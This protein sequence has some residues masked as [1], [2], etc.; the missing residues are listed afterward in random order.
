[1]KIKKEY[2]L[3]GFLIILIFIIVRFFL[4]QNNIP[5]YNIVPEEKISD[6]NNNNI[7]IEEK[8]TG[9]HLVTYNQSA[10]QNSF[11]DNIKIT[12]SNDDKVRFVIGTIDENSFV[13][14][15]FSFE[16]ECKKGEN[17][18]NLFKQRYFVKKGEYLFMD[19]F[20]Q[21]ILFTNEDKNVKSLVQ[22]DADKVAGNM[23]IK[24]SNYILPF[25]YSLKEVKD[26][27]VLFIGN[28]ITT[29]NGGKGIDATSDEFDYYSITKTR[30]ENMFENLNINRVNIS[31]WE[32]LTGTTER[33]LWLQENIKDELFQN[34]DLIIIQLGE[35][36]KE[37]DIKNMETD[38]AN[39]IDKIRKNSQNTEIIWLGPW[40]N[41][42]ENMLLSIPGICEKLNIKY[43]RLNDLYNEEYKSLNLEISK[44]EFFPNNEGMQVI[45]NRIIETLGFEF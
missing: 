7:V 36:Y 18:F 30:L 24:E 11:I 26:F 19:D 43:I 28:D 13:N 9:Y 16:L 23:I 27:S 25:E 34:R 1:M 39:L 8:V 2:F 10:N 42:N 3:I 14:E 40:N 38:I 29:R 31:D 4:P 20:G 45:S 15:R 32:K 41:S 17:E 33:K 37:L 22:S 6:E 5:N 44:N 35:N 12:A 21:D